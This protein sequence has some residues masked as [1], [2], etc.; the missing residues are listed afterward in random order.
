MGEYHDG[1][2]RSP[3]ENLV[4]VRQAIEEIWNQGNL[5][6]ADLLFSAAYVKAGGLVPGF[7]RGPEA[8][9]PT[10]LN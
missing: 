6:V 4:V 5:D 1:W 3:P 7:V 10:G 8:R 2:E 9:L